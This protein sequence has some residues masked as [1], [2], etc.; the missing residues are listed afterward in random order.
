MVTV[1]L[2]TGLLDKNGKEICEGD[3]LHFYLIHRSYRIEFENGAFLGAEIRRGETVRHHDRF[4]E[5][6]IIGNIF[7]HPE[8]KEVKG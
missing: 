4:R 2:F 1:M 3:V 5:G 6:R 7:E 8:L